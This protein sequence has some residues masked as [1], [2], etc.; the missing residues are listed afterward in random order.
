MLKNMGRPEYQAS[1]VYCLHVALFVEQGYNDFQEEGN[2][3][4]LLHSCGRMCTKTIIIIFHTL[5]AQKHQQH[6]TAPL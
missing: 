3:C 6:I 2:K 4:G 1:L 5:T